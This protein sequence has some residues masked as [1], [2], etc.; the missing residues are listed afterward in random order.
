[1]I[2]KNYLL[3]LLLLLLITNCNTTKATNNQDKNNIQQISKLRFIGEQVIPANVKF[4]NTK[5]GGLSSI[6]YANGAY[7]LISDDKQKPIRFY[8]MDLSFDTT[9]FFDFKITDVIEIQNDSKGLDPESL[10]FDKNSKNFIWT[11]EGSTR[12][13]ISPAIF[14]ITPNGESVKMYNTPEILQISATS[15]TEGPRKNGS[16][17]GLSMSKDSDYFWVGMEL[18]LLQDGDEPQLT[19][20]NY[21]VRISKINKNTGTLNFQ[22]AYQLEAIPKDSKPSNKFIV[23]GLPEILEIDNNR[24]LFIERAYASGHKN[25]GNTVK[26]FLV[27]ASNASDISKIKS[28]KNAN[29][30]PATKTLLF[31]FE[32]IRS[33]LTNGIV[34]N[35]EGGTFGKKLANGNRTLIV[36][37]D[38]N[39]NKFSKQLNQIIVFEILQ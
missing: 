39:F 20:G 5:V 18:P 21:P 9:S 8:K 15:K 23:N 10:R 7:Y 3:P 12:R 35:I 25:G 26:I 36:V 11:S 2:L 37:S 16:F 6:D 30:I 1:M 33:Q 34:D 24:F 19:K 29:Y 13:S 31:D 32:S 4:N 14:E 17:E 22:F 27:D 38:N 28:L